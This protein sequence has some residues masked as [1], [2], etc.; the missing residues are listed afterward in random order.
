[1]CKFNPKNKEIIIIQALNF[2]KKYFN[3]PFYNFG[4]ALYES[5]GSKGT[6]CKFSNSDYRIILVFM[7]FMEKYFS[8]NRLQNM[9]FEIY[10]H[11][12]RRKDL[13]RII[14]FWSKKLNI[15]GNTLKVYWK[16]NKVAR[17]RN[18]LD[19]V[20]QML[21]KIKGEKL[22]GSKIQAI[23][24]IILKKYQKR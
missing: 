3:D 7:K 6:T 9:G 1:M 4:I 23:S 19:Y 24:D 12:T 13:K 10:I 15:P 5:E 16:R 20:G 8:C 22:M 14:N 11:E 2:H 18:N 17:R 21:V